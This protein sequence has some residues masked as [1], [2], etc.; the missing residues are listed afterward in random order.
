MPTKGQATCEGHHQAT[1]GIGA[2]IGG[3]AGRSA[4]IYL[5]EA[6]PAT[7]HHPPRCQHHTAA[8]SRH[9]KMALGSAQ[10][11]QSSRPLRS[12]PRSTDEEEPR[13]WVTTPRRKGLERL[14]PTR[15]RA[16][17]KGPRSKPAGPHRH[18]AISGR[19]APQRPRPRRTTKKRPN[20]RAGGGGDAHCRRHR[21]GFARKLPPAG[22][23]EG[24]EGGGAEGGC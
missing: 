4:R 9:A 7:Q 3:L 15:P 20:E 23:E 10:P 14:G 16:G 11:G 22:P 12:E 2:A 8:P 21:L 6:S 5:R 13:R 19:P 1:S 18:G 17:L 24:E